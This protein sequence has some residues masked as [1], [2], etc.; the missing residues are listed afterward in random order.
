MFQ[1]ERQPL[2]TTSGLLSPPSMRANLTAWQCRPAGEEN[3]SLEWNLVSIRAHHQHG[4]IPV[5]VCMRPSLVCHCTALAEG[6]Q[7]P[8]ELQMV[9]T[10]VPGFVGTLC[11]Q[12]CTEVRF[13]FCLQLCH[14]KIENCWGCQSG[15]LEKLV[16][17]FHWVE[18]TWNISAC[19]ISSSSQ[20]DSDGQ[21][22]QGLRAVVWLWLDFAFFLILNL[23]IWIC[24]S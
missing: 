6:L 23:C 10:F 20:G 14:Y 15:G 8:A 13:A 3:T 16:W 19:D 18:N 9:F 11:L 24:F 5:M 1:L 12:E 17:L 7:I 4:G 21:N 22:F 2:K